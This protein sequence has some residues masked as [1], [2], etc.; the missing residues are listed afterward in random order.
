MCYGEHS[1]TRRTEAC[2]TSSALCLQTPFPPS[3]RTLYI[4]KALLGYCLKRPAVRS[5]GA[6]ASESPRIAPWP[7]GLRPERPA[8]RRCLRA[9][10]ARVPPARSLARSAR[11]EGH[12][13]R[14]PAA[15]PG[16]GPVRVRRE[17]AGP[18][19][20]Q[21]PF[22]SL[23]VSVSAIFFRSLPLKA[24]VGIAC[25]SFAPKKKLQK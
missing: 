18:G 15:A 7:R 22:F 9:A 21:R 12:V 23:P 1:R 17:W 14:R 13:A 11:R 2:N 10:M 19:D 3:G 16:A 8:C 25:G 24:P 6:A 5:R 4:A 20:V